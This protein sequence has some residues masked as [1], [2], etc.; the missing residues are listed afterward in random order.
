MQLI[1][2]LLRTGI[3]T[4]LSRSHY[5]NLWPFSRYSNDYTD[6]HCHIIQQNFFTPL[7]RIEWFIIY[8]ANSQPI[9][10]DDCSFFAISSIPVIAS[11]EEVIIEF[12]SSALRCE[13]KR[14]LDK[15]V[16]PISFV[17]LYHIR[18]DSC[19]TSYRFRNEFWKRH[20]AAACSGN[21]YRFIALTRAV[22]RNT[23]LDVR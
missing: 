6:M 14:N 22:R 20:C 17:L 3:E 19:I 4:S 1:T 12:A 2:M 23:N 18:T 11:H 8:F 10:C 16:L 7:Q 9:Q 5:E 21:F 13:T 15:L